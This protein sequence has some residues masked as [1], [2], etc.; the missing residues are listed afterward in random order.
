[1]TTAAPLHVLVDIGHPGDVHLFYPPI[2]NWLAQ[3][4]RVTI[5]ASQKDVTIQLLDN[6]KLP[7]HRVGIRRPGVLNLVW[8]LGMRTLRIA[9]VAWQD[10]PDIFVSVCS[11]TAAIASKMVRRPH[12]VFDDS[13]FGDEQIMLYKPFTDAICTPQQFERDL[14]PRQV[15]YNG[16]KELAYLHPSVFTPDPDVLRALEIDP[17]ETLFVLRL[18]SWDAAHD[19]GAYGLSRAGQARLIARLQQAGRVIVSYEGHPPRDL[20]RPDYPIPAESML[21]LL[22]YAH[23]FVS[24]GLTMVTEAS[25]LGTPS[26]LV[27]TLQ[28]GN[29]TRLK[30]A[31]LAAQFTDD[32]ATLHQVET[33]LANPQLKAEMAARHAALLADVIDVSAWVTQFVT[34][35]AQLGAPESKKAASARPH[36]SG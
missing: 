11:P 25:L 4:H 35:F 33:W 30:A 15:R 5:T 20:S 27:N 2:Q 29:I 34:D 16:F 12:V 22:A 14:G 9:R 36:K 10:R 23:L 17:D 3:G 26:I 32:D 7:F 1:M 18:V 13:E 21:H 28:A 8:L 31:G 6:Y 19:R 24:E